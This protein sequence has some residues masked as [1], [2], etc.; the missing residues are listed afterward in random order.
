MPAYFDKQKRTWY[1]QFR[2]KDYSGRTRS[3][4]KR[5]FPRKKDAL[6][7][8]KN[9]KTMQQGALNFPFNMLI[10]R[11]LEHQKN[12][13]RPETYTNAC[14]VIDTYIRPFFGTLPV[15]DITTSKILDWRDKDI[16]HR[17]FAPTTL[18]SLQARL[19]SIFNYA[20]R[21]YR[22]AMNPA[23]Q[24]G[25]MGSLRRKNEY[26]IWT[27]KELET[28]CTYIEQHSRQPQRALVYRV[29]FYSGMRPAEALALHDTDIDFKRQQLSITKSFHEQKGREYYTEPKNTYS[30]RKIAMPKFIMD[31][32]QDFV[33]QRK[34]LGYTGRL[35][36]VN[37]C[38]LNSQIR[39]ISTKLKLP[40]I[41]LYDL[42]HSHA[43]SLIAMHL[44]INLIAKRMG[45]SSPETTLRIYSHLYNKQDNDIADFL[46]K[47]L[48][49]L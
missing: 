42:R 30:R 40:R 11:Y 41:R 13:V 5:G 33:A 3:T 27:R 32:L 21:Y 28:F 6:E 39:Y 38:T 20:R 1:V 34:K 48:D 12:V 8:E 19:S 25:S 18:K 17:G 2:Y 43:S 46:D 44:D 45:H 22:L 37:T 14:Y 7:Y 10:D 29:L 49:K 24:A 35:F 15:S 26:R 31:E 36:P 23:V 47:N 9:Y 4:T 16:M